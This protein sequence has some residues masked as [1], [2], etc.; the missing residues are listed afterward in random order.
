V[1]FRGASRRGSSLRPLRRRPGTVT[2]CSSPRHTRAQGPETGRCSRPQRPDAGSTSPQLNGKPPIATQ[3]ARTSWA[4][5]GLPPRPPGWPGAGRSAA[6]AGSPGPVNASRSSAMRASGCRRRSRP[7]GRRVLVF[8]P[9]L[10]RS[11]IFAGPGVNSIAQ[12]AG[13][14]P[15]VRA[16]SDGPAMIKSASREFGTHYFT[17]K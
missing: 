13:D 3:P 12:A 15:D 9:A 6:R 2:A 5:R 17:A 8:M 16:G 11:L 1:I 4:A 10:A 14:Q 7:A